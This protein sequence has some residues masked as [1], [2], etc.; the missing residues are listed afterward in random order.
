MASRQVKYRGFPLQMRDKL[1]LRL[2]A[3]Q[4]A[5][6]KTKTINEIAKELKALDK[7]SRGNAVAA[8]F[9]DK[10][11]NYF[12][13]NPFG[14]DREIQRGTDVFL[15]R[16]FLD[17]FDDAFGYAKLKISVNEQ[18]K[19]RQAGVAA[20]EQLLL[21]LELESDPSSAKKRGRPEEPRYRSGNISWDTKSFYIRGNPQIS[22]LSE[23]MFGE[24]HS[25]KLLWDDVYQYVYKSTEN[26]NDGDW[27]KLNAVIIRLNSKLADNEIPWSVKKEAG[28]TIIL[29]YR[30]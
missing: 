6:P 17:R 21:L 25:Q 23:L 7:L 15:V 12:P 30:G 5:L 1:K 27:K 28:G 13:P 3:I 20:C 19:I 10:K 14:R 2:R 22:N 11:G 9:W 26:V 16:K 8:A 24:G 4:K 18:Q 29:L